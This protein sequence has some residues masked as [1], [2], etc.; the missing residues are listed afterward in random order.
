MICDANLNPVP[1]LRSEE[2]EYVQQKTADARRLESMQWT[3]FIV[4]GVAAAAGGY[5]LWRWLAGPSPSGS[6]RAL[7]LVPLASGPSLGPGLTL[8]GGM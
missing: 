7:R 2:Q 6:S 4:G 5:F 3:S 8:A 1:P